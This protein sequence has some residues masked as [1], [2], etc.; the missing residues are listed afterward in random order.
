MRESP[1]FGTCLPG[2]ELSGTNFEGI[3][4]KRLRQRLQ[5]IT[6]CNSLQVNVGAEEGQPLSLRF[7][8]SRLNA[9]II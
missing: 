5:G 7:S 6:A 3:P 1:S 2:H 8:W 4:F 9:D